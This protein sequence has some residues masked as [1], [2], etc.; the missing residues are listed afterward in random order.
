MMDDEIKALR[1][2]LKLVNTHAMAAKIA[3]G[4]AIQALSLMD[5]KMGKDFERLFDQ[6][7]DKVMD[8][9]PELATELFNIAA[10]SIKNR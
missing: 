8:R 6:V 4:F 1:A 5:A 7:A 10:Q 2:E 3:A 9:E